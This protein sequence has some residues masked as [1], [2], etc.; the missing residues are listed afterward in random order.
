MAFKAVEWVRRVRDAQ[1]EQTRGMSFEDRLAF[2]REKSEASRRKIAR[3]R[4][5]PIS[6]E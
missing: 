4:K 6:S 1:Y 2:Y 5:K 3:M